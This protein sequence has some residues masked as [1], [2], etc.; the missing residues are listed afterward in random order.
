MDPEGSPCE[1][2]A[3]WLESVT[4]PG[5]DPFMEQGPNHVEASD[6]GQRLDPT[7]EREDSAQILSGGGLEGAV[8]LAWEGGDTFQGRYYYYYSY[9]YIN[10]CSKVRRRAAGRPG[11]SEQSFGRM[12]GSHWYME[13]RGARGQG[14][15]GEKGLIN[16]RQ[17][18]MHKE[19]LLNTV[20]R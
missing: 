4:V 11:S 15:A 1:T 12:G 18:I 9:S 2:L 19:S 6:Q 14:E 10:Y 7:W 5:R 17:S 3:A 13:W 8:R 16:V 20:D